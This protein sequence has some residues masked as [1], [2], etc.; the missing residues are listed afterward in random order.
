MIWCVVSTS[1]S[2]KA[3]KKRCRKPKEIVAWVDFYGLLEPTLSAGWCLYSS[4]NEYSDSGD[5]GHVVP[6]PMIQINWVSNTSTL[7][8]L[9]KIK[10]HVF[11]P[12]LISGPYASPTTPAPTSA[13]PQRTNVTGG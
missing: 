10:A 9:P 13:L 2:K 11:S 1:P 8:V 3:G 5:V 12:A 7:Y 6:G 4:F